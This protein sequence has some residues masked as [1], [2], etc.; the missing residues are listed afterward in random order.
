V[1]QPEPT[2]AELVAAAAREHP[3]AHPYSLSLLIEVRHGR[4]VTG[5]E[6]ARLLREAKARLTPVQIGAERL[7]LSE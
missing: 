5:R 6:V 3:G 2:M 7:C 4:T 1:S